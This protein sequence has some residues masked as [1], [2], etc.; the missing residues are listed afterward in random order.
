MAQ[1]YGPNPVYCTTCGRE[2]DPDARFCD[3]CGAVLDRQGGGPQ[4][5]PGM[6]NQ[7]GPA[8]GDAQRIPNYL[9]QAILL[10][11]FGAMT[12]C[13]YLAGLPTLATGIVAIVFA[14]QVEGKVRSG[15]IDGALSSSRKARTWCW[16]SLGILLA[17][18]V[19]G[20]L[21]VFILGFTWIIDSI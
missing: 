20:I 13:C 2:S 19:L 15:D 21:L 17:G 11:I 7:G 3:N 9:V 10:T 16:V 6:P 1:H 12:S 14:S 8:F 5:A 4:Y 18:V